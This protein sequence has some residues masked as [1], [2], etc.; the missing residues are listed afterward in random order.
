MDS[1]YTTNSIQLLSRIAFVFVFLLLELEIRNMSTGTFCATDVTDR[2]RGDLPIIQRLMEAATVASKQFPVPH[3]YDYNLSTEINYA[4]SPEKQTESI[5][6]TF[7][8]KYAEHRS[9][10]DYSYHGYY[11][12]ERQLFHDII[13]DAFHETIIKDGE[14]TCNV[15]TENW[16]VFTAGAMGV[17]KGFVLRWM[18]G[19][20]IFPMDAFV[21]VDPDAIRELL[22]ESKD[23]F[24]RDPYQGII[25]K[26]I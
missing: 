12:P 17:G 2:T 5:S 9:Q 3:D 22:P 19:E 1:F 16:M 13:I 11:T 6:S 26:Y 4:Y 14:V 10:L 7:V 23:Y 18:N 8:G 15:P 20:G 25:K 21:R 24:S